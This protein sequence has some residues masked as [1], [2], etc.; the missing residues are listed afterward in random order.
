MSASTSAALGER[1]YLALLGGYQN[2]SVCRK[3]FVGIESL[4]IWLRWPV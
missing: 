1:P 4:K 2:N 3:W